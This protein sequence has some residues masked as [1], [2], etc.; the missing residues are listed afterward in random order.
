MVVGESSGS[1]VHNFIFVDGDVDLLELIVP[2][3]GYQPRTDDRKRKREGG[4]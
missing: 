2:E 1:V 4:G 3:G